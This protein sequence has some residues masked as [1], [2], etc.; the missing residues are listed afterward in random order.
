MNFSVVAVD[1]GEVHGVVCIV[2]LMHI[3]NIWGRTVWQE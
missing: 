3:S 1:D 2:L